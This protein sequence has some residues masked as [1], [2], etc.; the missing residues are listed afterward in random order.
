MTS[1]LFVVALSALVAM[2]SSGGG[3]LAAAAAP[4]ANWQRYVLSRADPERWPVRVVSTSGS[5]TDPDAVLRPG[6]GRT[7]IIRRP[8]EPAPS[9][10]LD[11]GRDVGGVP[12]FGVVAASGS[13][14]LKVGYA[15][16]AR[17]LTADGDVTDPTL[18]LAHD[19]G[20]PLRYDTYQVTG[21]GVIDNRFIQGAERYQELTLDSPG[22]VTLSFARIR[23]TA[24][25]AGPANYAGYFLS[26]SDQLNRL[27]YAGAYTLDLNMLPPKA[28]SAFWTIE[29]G[30][31]TDTGG[32]IGL[33]RAGQNWT[34]Y[35][36]SFRF[37]I[38][39]QQAGFVVRGASGDTGYLLTLD[40]SADRLGPANTLQ[41]AVLDAGK[42]HVIANQPLLAPLA[43]G[44]W[45]AVDVV[46]RGGTV[47]TMLDG[48]QV[49]SFDTTALPS[50]GIPVP[51]GTVGFDETSG[52]GEATDF[53]DLTVTA[54]D[55]S[56][57]YHNSL[58][59][60]ATLADFHQPGVNDGALIFDG[61]KRDR[62]VWEGD[63]VVAQPTLFYSFGADEYA[64]DSLRLLG[65]YQLASGFVEGRRVPADPPV[66]TG[67]LPGTVAR[68]SASYSMYFVTNLSA[69][70]LYTGDAAFVRAEWPTVRRELAWN[71]E[72]VD[73]RGLFVTHSDDGA[74]WHYNDQTGEQAYE[75]VLYY[76]TLRDGADL[77]DAVGDSATAGTYRARAAAVRDAV[78]RY[79]FNPATGVYDISPTQR[80]FVAQDANALAIEYGVA[81][82][83]RVPGILAAMSRTLSTPYGNLDVSSPAP[84]NYYPIIG[85]FMASSELS[86]RFAAGDTAGAFDLL[87]REWGRMLTQDSTGTLWEMTAPNGVPGIAGTPDGRVSLAHAWSTGPTPALS[88]YV[89]GIAPTSPGYRT[90]QVAPET[91][92]LA[93]A[94]GRAPT[95]HG[96]IDV[97]WTQR[98]GEV[99]LDVTAPA[100]TTGTI[101]VPLPD[102]DARV[103]VNG[104]PVWS[105]GTFHPAPGVTS[106]Q[107]A[108]SV[109]RISVTGG[110]NYHID[111]TG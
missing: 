75:N 43:P 32:D 57:L 44:G 84:A 98:S 74:S 77:A 1:R 80:G 34:D 94:R 83:G 89:L 29:D 46:A 41:E 10:V 16:Q 14:R 48:R 65:S 92:P 33:L 50:G 42:S 38:N 17:F 30:H 72:Q 90:W 99:T 20:D 13:P 70:Y 3:A 96:P 81:P 37:R 76:R 2:G 71:A 19:S 106:A 78:N 52:A 21:P 67:P 9:L 45:H 85:P 91:G 111:S 66:T 27:W 61:A 64:R 107:P 36:T 55:G 102:R 59:D 79:L 68:Y 104:I 12:E 87:N 60:P 6:T 24:Y 56:L 88:E 35:T 82:A 4:N 101:V 62:N 93:W 15:E 28:P 25:P 103:S 22:S 49:G 69:Y 54:P 58:S 11:Y 18:G 110:T 95:P 5:V 8:G 100:G 73:T 31:L 108:N 7:T 51:S 47:T 40:D 86:A 63:L 109:L 39:G 23:S 105:G 53:A 97:A 26:S